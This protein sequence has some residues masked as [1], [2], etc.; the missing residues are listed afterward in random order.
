MRNALMAGLVLYG[1]NLFGGNWPAW[2]GPHGTGVCDEP[3]L[4]TTWGTNQNVKWRSPL[5]E[6][7]NSTPIVWGNRIFLT[8]AIERKGTPNSSKPH[9]RG[10][11]CFDR[12]TGKVVWE[13]GIDVSEKEPTHET[14]PYA[15]ASPVTD[16]ERVIVS[17]G[18]PGLY[19]YDFA[20]KELW[21]RDLGPQNHIWGN[22]ASPVIYR[23]L[24]IL[25]FGPGERTFL[26]AVDKKTGKTI[27]QADEPGG[28]SGEKKPAQEKAVWIGSWTTPVIAHVE[29]HDELLM[30]FPSRVVSFDPMS[31]KESW[32][33]RG[34]NPLVY[35]SPLYADGVV[36]AMGGFGGSALAVKTGGRGDVTQT[37]RLWQIPRTKQRI[38]SG[39]IAGG[40][41]YILDDPGVAECIE[42][43]TGKVVWEQ[44]LKG[45]G[46]KA[47]NWSSMVRAGDKLYAVNQSGDGFV[48]RAS[49][50]FEVM[51]TN[52]L[53]ET[54]IASIA[55]S[56]GELFIRSYKALW[57][58][59]GKK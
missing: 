40:H 47:D 19:A 15:A 5:P 9:R 52:S 55:P 24:C 14:N 46:A 36:V 53:R 33:C 43:R 18:S 1:A 29:D 45:P 37:H 27:W 57:C 23:D 42:L 11:M 35:T 30:S 38:G 21:H 2:R 7:G 44:R 50:T 3:D 28:D 48:I 54:T 10:L 13:S 34:L 4:P 26:V 58:I 49:P 32:S 20:G 8:Q 12:D 59:S 31:G 41:I 22:G 39:V 16:G 56:D 17:Y 6:R 25:N 51:S